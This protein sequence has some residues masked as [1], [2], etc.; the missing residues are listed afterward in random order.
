MEKCTKTKHS[1]LFQMCRSVVTLSN[2]FHLNSVNYVK[3]YTTYD[4]IGYDAPLVQPYSHYEKV[5]H[6]LG[7][8]IQV[9]ISNMSPPLRTL[10]MARLKMSSCYIV[11]TEEIAQVSILNWRQSEP[12]VCHWPWKVWYNHSR[13]PQRNVVLRFSTQYLWWQC[14]HSVISQY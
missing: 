12:L 10:N 9:N 1:W 13:P 8:H 5:K 6:T 14:N 7:E 11:N 3:K 2:V 4:L